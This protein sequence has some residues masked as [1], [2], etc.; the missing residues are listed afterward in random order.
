MKTPDQRADVNVE[1]RV[2]LFHFHVYVNHGPSALCRLNARDTAD[3]SGII[4][5]QAYIW[6]GSEQQDVQKRNACA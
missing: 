1:I 3:E 2:S 5:T 6:I 4:D